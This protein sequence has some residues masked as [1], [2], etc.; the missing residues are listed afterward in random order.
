MV[1]KLTGGRQS[2]IVRTGE[3]VR[4]FRMFSPARNRV[5]DLGCG[6]TPFLAS[7]EHCRVVGVDY[8]KDRFQKIDISYERLPFPDESFDAVTAWAVFEHLENPFFAMREVRR[9]LKPGGRFFM[10][11]PN[12][13][14]IGSRVLFFLYGDLP[15][16][17]RRN[18]HIFVPLS[19]IIRKTFARTF[20]LVAVRYALPTFLGIALPAFL[21]NKHT[22]RYVVWVFE[23]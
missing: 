22:G 23:K 2:E 1:I 20:R 8:D 6:N 19:A 15:R 17:R 14:H 21:S 7:T 3:A 18:D 16:W 11:V 5:L 9:V 4:I 12:S 13:A 10:S